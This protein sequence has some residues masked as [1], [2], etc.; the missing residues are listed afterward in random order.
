MRPSGTIAYICR[1][2]QYRLSSLTKI[3]FISSGQKK[4]Q[5]LSMLPVVVVLLLIAIIIEYFYGSSCVPGSASEHFLIS[6]SP[7]NKTTALAQ[8]LRVRVSLNFVPWCLTYL[9]PTLHPLPAL[10]GL[11]RQRHMEQASG[12]AAGAN[13]RREVWFERRFSLTA[14]G[15]VRRPSPELCS[16]GR[17]PM[18][19]F[20]RQVA[21]WRGRCRAGIPPI[22]PAGEGHMQHFVSGPQFPPLRGQC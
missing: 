1:T 15:Q 5:I 2:L 6:F 19:P 14:G 11:V 13:L 22:C 21:W 8:P 16:Q 12:A 4:K 3:N 7:H 10:V 20:S 17:R 18:R 9:S